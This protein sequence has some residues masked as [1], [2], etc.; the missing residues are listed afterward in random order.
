MSYCRE[1][2][3]VETTL[4]MRSVPMVHGEEEEEEYLDALVLDAAVAVPHPSF[5][6]PE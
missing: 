4:A 2:E 3:L 6:T 1:D 5:A